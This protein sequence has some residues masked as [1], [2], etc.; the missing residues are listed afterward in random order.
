MSAMNWLTI[1]AKVEV[2]M[3]EEGLIGSRYPAKVIATASQ[4]NKA[5]VEYSAFN[6]EGDEAKS[7]KEWVPLSIVTPPPPPPPANFISS[8]KI[9]QTLEVF[10]EDGWWGVTLLKKRKEAG[11]PGF[12]VGSALYKTEHW[13]EEANLRPPWTFYGGHWEAAGKVVD[14][15]AAPS[16]KPEKGKAKAKAAA[17]APAPAAKRKREEKAKGGGSSKAPEAKAVAAP[18]P[19]SAKASKG[20]GGGG[21]NNNTAGAVGG[22]AGLTL[23]QRV[24]KIIVAPVGL[25]QSV[26]TPQGVD[27][28]LTLLRR[29]QAEEE[30]NAGLP[31]ETVD[32]RLWAGAAQQ[33]WRLYATSSDGH[34]KYISPAG[35]S[36]NSRS[37]ALMERTDKP[38]QP[39]RPP[40][41]DRARG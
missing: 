24:Q 35:K 23:K 31:D 10:F 13:A 17:E 1:G 21:D 41:R 9:G 29:L 5:Q 6:E 36:C 3:Q 37:E 32:A 18:V 4:A 12:L 39:N 11:A 40:P 20:G 26:W 16:K 27:A 19:A 7:L 30:A 15:D 34:Y 8:L 22:W 2:Q 28:T 33:G 14:V 25:Y 38:V